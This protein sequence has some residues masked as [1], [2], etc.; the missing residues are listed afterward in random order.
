MTDTVS[1]AVANESEYAVTIKTQLLAFSQT[2]TVSN[3]SGTVN[4]SPIR[5]VLVSCVTLSP[6]FFVDPSG[7]F[8]YALNAV[9]STIS[10][11][12]IEATGALTAVP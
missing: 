11:Y 3:G 2:C 7:R 12:K 1:I 6:R 5:S 4:K 10:V 8:A 9:F